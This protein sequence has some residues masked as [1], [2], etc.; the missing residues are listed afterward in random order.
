MEIPKEYFTLGEVLARWQIPEADLRYLAETDELRLSFVVFNRYLEL[1]CHEEIDK[2]RFARLPWHYGR[3]QG[4]LDLHPEDVHALFRYG[5]WRVSQFRHADADYGCLLED[6][7]FIELRVADLQV[8]R[9][10]RDRLEHELGLTPIHR[11]RPERVVGFQATRD[12]RAVVIA[13]RAFKLGPIQARIVKLLHHAALD[14]TP[15]QSGKEILTKAGSRCLRMQDVFK[16]Q[17][18]WRELIE[19]DGRGAYRLILQ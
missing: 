8:R 11:A 2:G 16:S 19:S 17:P 4:L 1:G 3:F 18:G 14:G 9:A 7:D 6:E 12:Y 5:A 15:W 10:E 13:N